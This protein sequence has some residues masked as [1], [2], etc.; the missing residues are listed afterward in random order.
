MED[1]N[2]P[3]CGT[4]L[5]TIETPVYS[6]WGGIELELCLNDQCVYFLRSWKILSHQAGTL[7]GYRY[8][9]DSN[10][11]EGPFVVGSIDAFKEC[12]ITEA[13]KK[14]RLEREYREEKE[15]R[16]LLD[17]IE[18]AKE[19]NDQQLVVWLRQLKKLKYP[20]RS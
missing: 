8:Y 13:E 5:T 16:D 17:A 7:V 4:Q 2:C 9:H 1:I 19:K 15:F 10:G 12:V 3:H 18:Q 6:K 14:S 11:Q 20:N